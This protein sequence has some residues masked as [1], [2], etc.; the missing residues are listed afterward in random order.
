MNDS[1]TIAV[2]FHEHT[3][4][5]RATIRSVLGQTD[6]DWRLL[7]VDDS[8]RNLA[9]PVIDEFNDSRIRYIAHSDN[10]GMVPTWNDCLDNAETDLVSIVHSDDV[11]GEEYVS[12]MR[13]QSKDWPDAAAFFC[14]VRIIDPQGKFTTTFVDTV[15]R[16]LIGS[17]SKLQVFAGEAG[18]CR[19]LR[20]NIIYCPTLCYRKSVIKDARFQQ[21]LKYAIDLQFTLS[22]LFDG[23][24]LVGFPQR[25]YYYR[26]HEGSITAWS[27]STGVRGEDE[28]MLYDW[29]GA[30][31]EK[32]GWRRAV[33]LAK[34]RTVIRVSLL[35]QAFCDACRLSLP[36]AYKKLALAAGRLS[37]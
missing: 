9:Q 5:L 22:L 32:Q 16:V 28:W 3:D 25:A 30:V 2:P 35:V 29:A 26:R 1:I 10:L 18:V 23:K 36:L 19:L 15:K 4:Y 24:K 12:I 27:L 11:L 13:E 37:P 14:Q 7:V 33:R 8:G 17:I 20:G 6:T 31:A 34:R 21:W